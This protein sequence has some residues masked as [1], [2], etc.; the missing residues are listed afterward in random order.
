MTDIKQNE[1]GLELLLARW[2][3]RFALNGDMYVEIPLIDMERVSKYDDYS[4][5][6]YCGDLGIYTFDGI[7]YKRGVVRYSIK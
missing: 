7:D 6:V 4:K 3:K 1:K 2:V 5:T